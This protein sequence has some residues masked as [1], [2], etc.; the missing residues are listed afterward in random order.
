MVPTMHRETKQMLQSGTQECIA[1]QR[2]FSDCLVARPRRGIRS[3]PSAETNSENATSKREGGRSERARHRGSEHRAGQGIRRRE[4][5]RQREKTG[6]KREPNR[7]EAVIV[8]L[9]CD[10]SFRRTTT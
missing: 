1:T 2:S 10:C 8:L 9:F 7:R 4:E 5:L 3:V 6:E